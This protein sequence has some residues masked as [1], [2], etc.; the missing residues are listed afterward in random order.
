MVYDFTSYYDRRKNGSVKW[1]KMNEL[2]ENPSND[3]I[4]M[5]TADMDF[6]TC[7]K[8]V[9]AVT[10]YVSTEVMGYS[11][12]TDAY[13]ESTKDFFNDMHHFSIEK[14]W[15]VTTPGI[16]SALST[17]VRTF[18][19]K[20]EGVIVMP[21]VYNPFY[22][23]VE[24]Q[25]R[26]LETC[27][28]FLKNNRYYMDFNKLEKLAKKN[29]VKMLLLCSPHNPGGRIWTKEELQQLIDIAIDYNLIVVSDDIHAD[30]NL[31]G[32]Q[33]HILPTVDTKIAQN[34]V[35]CTAAS[36]TFNIAGL[37]C[38]N[39]I[40]PNRRLRR[41]F[42]ETNLAA[43]IEK[44]NILGLV[45]TKAAYDRCRDWL[46]EMKSIIDVNQTL[47]TTFFANLSPKFKVMEQDA[48][49]LAWVDYSDLNIDSKEFNRFLSKECDFYINDGK[50]YGS[51]AKY[52]I[53]INVGMPTKQL[54]MNLERFRLEVE[55]W[56]F[57]L[58]TAQEFI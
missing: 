42:V 27:P 35:I 51:S 3:V 44:A 21:P 6:P 7:P 4:P 40:I 18:A 2:N 26:R 46:Y 53:R 20:G 24:N 22:E 14:E 45:A 10:N 34:C 58:L 5:T 56:D 16:V 38:S 50:M 48:S 37:Q 43:G 36:K 8:I 13:L 17:S 15:I 33:H 39:I 29:D 25:H 30:I 49:F 1:L 9:D 19:K 52:F 11:V 32:K 41:R 57:P 23:V 55:K 31:K 12:P 28:L 47:V 54:K